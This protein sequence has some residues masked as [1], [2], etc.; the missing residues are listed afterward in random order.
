MIVWVVL[1]VFD[2]FV[3]KVVWIRLVFFK[4]V[5]RNNNSNYNSNYNNNK[6]INNNK[7]RLWDLVLYSNNNN[8]NNRGRGFSRVFRN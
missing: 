4:V 5:N 8:N 7:D 3:G 6:K 2:F 1:R